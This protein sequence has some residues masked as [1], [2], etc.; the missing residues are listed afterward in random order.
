M[1]IKDVNE[2]PPDVCWFIEKKGKIL[3]KYFP[4]IARTVNSAGFVEI[5]FTKTDELLEKVK[6]L[7]LDKI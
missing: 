5:A 2:L 1:F 6:E 3:L 7:K 4:E